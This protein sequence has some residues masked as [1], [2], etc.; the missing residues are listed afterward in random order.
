MAASSALG[1]ISLAGQAYIDVA[2]D[3]KLTG[4]CS[5]FLL[6]IAESGERKTT[7]DNCFSESISNHDKDQERRMKPEL[8]SYQA[9]YENHRSKCEGIR[10]KIKQLA[11][12]GE[13]NEEIKK[14]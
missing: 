14:S 1:A 6:T 10:L 3:K 2:R 5:I 8:D 9:D 12:K 13:K 11:K 4:P 7:C